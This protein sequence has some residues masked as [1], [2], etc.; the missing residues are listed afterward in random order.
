MTPES[1]L[2]PLIAGHR[3]AHL[4]IEFV[5]FVHHELETRQNRAAQRSKI[6][7]QKKICRTLCTIKPGDDHGDE[8]KNIV[9][10]QTVKNVYHKYDKSLQIKQYQIIQCMYMRHM[11]SGPGYSGRLSFRRVLDAPVRNYA[12]PRDRSG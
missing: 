3:V 5:H 1:G 6:G 8:T 7:Q 10:L 2:R 11:G 12:Y 4:P 9:S